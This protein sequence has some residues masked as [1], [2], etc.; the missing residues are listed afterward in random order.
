[1]YYIVEDD[2]KLMRVSLEDAVPEP[3]LVI[4][5][6]DRPWSLAMDGTYL[7]ISIANEKR[8]AKLN[9]LAPPYELSTVISDVEG[10]SELFVQE[11]ELFYIEEFKNRV[12][13]LNLNSPDPKCIELLGDIITPIDLLIHNNTLYVTETFRGNLLKLDL[14]HENISKYFDTSNKYLPES[15]WKLD[16]P[17]RPYKPKPIHHTYTGGQKNNARFL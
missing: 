5:N 16:L 14:G 2:D 1:M 6:I 8:I 15:Y 4:D 9:L 10:P 3:E 12:C 7:L 11:K 17:K 13:K